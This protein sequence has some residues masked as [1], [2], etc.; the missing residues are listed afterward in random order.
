[1]MTPLI[2]IL[3]VDRSLLLLFPTRIQPS[4]TTSLIR[5]NLTL[6]VNPFF[7]WHSPLPLSFTKRMGNILII[8]FLQRIPR[9]AAKHQPRNR[10]PNTAFPIALSR[11][12]RN[13]SSSHSTNHAGPNTT[14]RGRK[15][16]LR[17]VESVRGL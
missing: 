5:M 13:D 3:L 15:M 11:L 7:R 2:R 4:A 14:V 16:L 8:P 17:F 9:Q 12:L 10:R 1:M 6:L